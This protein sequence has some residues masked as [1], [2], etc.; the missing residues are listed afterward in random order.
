MEYMEN[1]K[2]A[3]VYHRKKTTDTDLIYVGQTQDVE[4]EMRK[5][6][7]ESE[8]ITIDKERSQGN[9]VNTRRTCPFGYRENKDTKEFEVVE[10]EAEKVRK[11]CEKFLEYSEHPPKELVDA[12]IEDAW[13]GRDEK[14]TYEEAEKLVSYD[15]IT[16]YI[17]KKLGLRHEINNKEMYFIR[18]E[19]NS[20]KTDI[21]TVKD[22]EPIITEGQWR[23]TQQML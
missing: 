7:S 22:A 15:E 12:K 23:K 5:K 6:F 14:L 17:E 10:E 1:G 16:R 2:K 3:A 13:E 19:R 20:Y 11:V 9:S 4:T 8:I 21:R 18:G